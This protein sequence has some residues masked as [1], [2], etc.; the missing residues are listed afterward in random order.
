MTL[1]QT[2]SVGA[3]LA[4]QGRSSPDRPRYQLAPSHSPLRQTGVSSSMTGSSSGRRRILETICY[5]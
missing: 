2:D 4:W 1:S 5:Q 3:A